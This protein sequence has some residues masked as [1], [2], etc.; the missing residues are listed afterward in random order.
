MIL[1]S[2]QEGKLINI[3]QLL[4]DNREKLL[5]D[6][7]PDSCNCNGGLPKYVYRNPAAY[8]IGAMLEKNEEWMRQWFQTA[9]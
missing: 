5:K 1:S 8:K 7:Q 4:L 3:L 9:K 6:F 2:E